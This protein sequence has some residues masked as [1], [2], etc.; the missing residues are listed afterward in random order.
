MEIINSVLF[1]LIN[2]FLMQFLL[3]REYKSLKFVLVP[4]VV[5]VVLNLFFGALPIRI[6]PI[7][8]VYS[9]GILVLNIMS[10]RVNVFKNN[11][12]VTQEKRERLLKIKYYLMH[13][14]VPIGVTVFQIILLFNKKVQAG[15]L[16]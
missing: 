1:V 11:T 9:V 12:S 10:S 8:L 4:A 14:V 16:K 5:F 6:I 7:A 15:I 13:F 2:A 3:K